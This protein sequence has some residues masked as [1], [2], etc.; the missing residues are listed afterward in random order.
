MID[1]AAAR[2]VDRVLQLHGLRIAEV[3]PLHGFGDDDRGLAV[4]REIHVVGIVDRDRLAGLARPGVDG[5]EAALLR[6]LG[7]V[8]H[9]QRAQVPRRDDVLRIEAHLELVDDLERGGIDHP[10]VVGLQVRH[11]DARQVAGDGR[12]QL[13][14]RGFAVQVG[15]VRHRRHSGNRHDG[16]GGRR[17]RPGANADCGEGRGGEQQCE[18]D[19]ACERT[20]NTDLLHVRS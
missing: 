10:D 1:A 14:R 7:V 13:G 11:V 2:H 3:Q 15:R 19:C 12:A 6:V 4:R 18:R 5:R 8:R 17:R 9:P 20:N 16:S